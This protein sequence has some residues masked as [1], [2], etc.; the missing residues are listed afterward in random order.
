LTEEGRDPFLNMKWI[1]P[2]LFAVLTFGTAIAVSASPPAQVG[3]S[4]FIESMVGPDG[5]R[6]SSVFYLGADGTCKQLQSM[7]EYSGGGEGPTYAPSQSGTYTYVSTPGNP[8]EATLTIVGAGINNAFY[9]YFSSDTSGG[10][11]SGIFSFLLASPNTFLTNVSNRITLQATDPAITGFVISGSA[12]RLVLIRTVGP[13]L[14][15]FGVSPV[16][17][18]PMLNL[19]MGTGANRIASGQPW[20]SVTGYDSQA[21]SWIFSVAGAFQLQPDSKD[22]VYFGLLYPGAYTAQSFDTTT[23]G[24]ALTEVY[25]LPYSG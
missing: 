1:T 19:F 11:S 23:S 6:D 16:S 4:F 2:L 10:I 13:S 7:H 8:L 22:V 12:P 5:I 18:H 15:Q 9:L 21:M 20:G 24:S 14:A 25:I 17:T 3:D